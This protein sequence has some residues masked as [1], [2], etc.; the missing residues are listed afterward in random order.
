M[1]RILLLTAALM[2]VVATMSVGTWAY[3]NDTETVVDNT[4]TAGT[5]TLTV[6][7]GTPVAIN[8]PDTY[9]G[10]KA[11]VADWLLANGGSIDGWLKIQTTAITSSD[12]SGYLTM[13]LWIDKDNDGALDNGTT[14]Q[15][16]YLANT[17]AI[18][19][20][21]GADNA[22]PDSAGALA[23]YVLADDLSSETWGTSGSPVL[24]IAGGA[25]TA[26]FRANYNFPD[27]SADQNAAQGDIV[28]FDLTFTLTQSTP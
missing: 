19:N 23:V 9:P 13:L 4:I 28:D 17:G 27:N 25:G 26:H 8:V 14:S 16:V 21:S 3:F 11:A 2:A 6:D 1:K 20:W 24:T 7:D 10:D 22:T 18:T 15:D 12:L 5:L